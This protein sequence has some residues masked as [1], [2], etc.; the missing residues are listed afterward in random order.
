MKR[1]NTAYDRTRTGRNT[2]QSG[3][4][5]PVT[6]PIPPQIRP[7]VPARRL[8]AALLE[9]FAQQLEAAPHSE[10]GQWQLDVLDLSHLAED[11]VQAVALDQRGAVR[12]GVCTGQTVRLAYV[13]IKLDGTTERVSIDI[14]RLAPWATSRQVLLAGSSKH[15]TA[16]LPT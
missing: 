1:V 16:Q 4:A 13:Q 12:H 2:L 8:P 9:P 6:D 11:Q 3:R 7:E 14:G 10:L 15:A 5:L